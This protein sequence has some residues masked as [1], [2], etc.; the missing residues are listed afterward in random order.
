MVKREDSG[1]IF[2]Q[3]KEQKNQK[4]RLATEDHYDGASK[5]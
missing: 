1:T 5:M 2:Q 4:E 3:Q